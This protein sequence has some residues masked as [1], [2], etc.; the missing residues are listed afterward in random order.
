MIRLV[1]TRLYVFIFTGNLGGISNALQKTFKPNKRAKYLLTI[2]L[3][4]SI[5]LKF[6]VI[7]I[8]GNAMGEGLVGQQLYHV[9][10]LRLIFQGSRMIKTACKC[11]INGG[12]VAP[13]T[14]LS[15]PHL[16]ALPL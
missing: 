1:T 8:A 6:T 16:L 11:M 9:F 3:T 7:R 15:W 14:Y 13:K 2:L 4:M 10:S 12:T 5:I